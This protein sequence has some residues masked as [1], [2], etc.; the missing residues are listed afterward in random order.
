[1]SAIAQLVKQIIHEYARDRYFIQFTMCDEQSAMKYHHTVGRAIRNKHKLW[2]NGPVAK[3]FESIGIWHADDMS[4]T[5]LLI[6]HRIVNSVPVDLRG[7]RQ[8]HI[9]YWTRMSDNGEMEF[10]EW[11]SGD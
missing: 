11:P 7:I 9:D 8:E 5:I 6:I 3:E 4:H 2:S 10:D 1:M